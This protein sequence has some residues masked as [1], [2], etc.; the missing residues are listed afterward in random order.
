MRWADT[1]TVLVWP[2][3][4]NRVAIS[5]S[6]FERAC[7]RVALLHGPPVPR[8]CAVWHLCFKYPFT[9]FDQ[10]AAAGGTTLHEHN[11]RQ[12]CAAT[13]RLHAIS[14]VRMQSILLQTAARTRTQCGGLLRTCYVAIR[15]Q[16]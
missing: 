5:S 7:T 1:T 14:E 10:L 15:F 4:T 11:K 12:H 6:Q 3:E 16:G 9:V 2:L 13:P 8:G